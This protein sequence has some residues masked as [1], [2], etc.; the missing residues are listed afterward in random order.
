MPRGAK[1]RVRLRYLAG[2]RHRYH[3]PDARPGAAGQSGQSAA[4]GHYLVRQPRRGLRQ[5]GLR[6]VWAK[7]TASSNFLN[8]PGNFTAS[9]LKWVKENEPAIYEQIYK[10]Q[11]PG[12]Y[13][14][15]QAH[16]PDADHGI[17]LVGRRVLE[18]PGAG[19]CPGSAGSLRHQ[20]ATCCPKW[21]RHLPGAGPAYAPKRRW[22]W[23]CTAGTPIS[24]R[25]GDQPN[26]AFSL[27]VLQPGEVAATAGT[28]RR[29][30]RH[31]RNRPP[32]RTR[33]SMPLPT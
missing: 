1:S 32:I 10:I 30:V 7:S 18:F 19:H 17:G 27:N 20:R 9:K 25:A 15:Y 23:V 2:G 12:D 33:A 29:R 14:A 4:P 21:L 16:G 28:S 22:S 8:S 24:Y 6:R 26:N 3:L 11:L 31:H 5:S 13:I